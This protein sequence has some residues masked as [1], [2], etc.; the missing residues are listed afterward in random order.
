MSNDAQKLT[1]VIEKIKRDR[2][3][4]SFSES[5]L[6]V[7]RIKELEEALN[8]KDPEQHMEQLLSV[9]SD[10]RAKLREAKIDNEELHKLWAETIKENKGLEAQLDKQ[11]LD[12]IEMQE[13]VARQGALLLE[14]EAQLD[15][16]KEKWQVKG[17]RTY[18]PSA[19]NPIALSKD[20]KENNNGN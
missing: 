14:V 4:F 2:V 17:T 8:A 19:I 9:I 11:R 5:V 10:L 6:A 13:S 3:G 15:A 1:E 12:N 20:K 18:G 7:E 16:E